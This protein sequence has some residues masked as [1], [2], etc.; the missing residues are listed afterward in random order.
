MLLE[1]LRA[2]LKELAGALKGLQEKEAMTA[3]DVKAIDDNLVEI[4]GVQDQIRALEAAEQA[5]QQ[6]ALPVNHP[7]DPA[8][9][10][11]SPAQVAEKLTAA[12]KVGLLMCGMVTALSTEGTRGWRPAL[13]AMSANGFDAL[14]KEFE[15]AQTRTLISANASAGGVLLPENM[16]NEIVDILRPNNTF[17]QGNPDRVPMPNGTYKLPAAASGATAKYHGEAKPKWVSQPSFKAINMSAKLLAGI[18]PISNQLI[19]WS[20]PDVQGWAQRDLSTALGTKMDEMLFFGTGLQDTPLGILEIPGVHHS[21]A[22]GGTAPTVAQ[23]D[24][25]A[26]AAL[27]PI[28][29]YA[30]LQL[31]VAW[32]MSP[33]VFGFLQ[34]MRDGNANPI[35]PTMQSNMPTWKGYP[36]IVTTQFPNNGGVGT[37]ESE[38]ALI[39]FGHVLFGDVMRM[40]LAISD[41]AT[42]VNGAQTINAFQDNVTLIR[43]ESEHDVDLRYVEA[44]EVIDAVRWGA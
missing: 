6:L 13:R 38:I 16:A 10:T 32:R 20:L 33:R 35:Y 8:V 2:R 40:Q 31:G 4:K 37:D 29:S 19:R 25:T 18:V 12:Q 22:Q 23:T 1:K 28:Q 9:A 34:D 39:A 26:R 21:T 3:E 15:G 43:A 42:V 14:A 5:Q 27:T 7:A 44:V 11:R 17:L 36:V 30:A 24:A 41:V